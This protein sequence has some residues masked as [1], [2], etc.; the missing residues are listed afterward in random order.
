LGARDFLTGL[1]DNR[2]YRDPVE[3]RKLV[4]R[5]LRVDE[6]TWCQA[7]DEYGRRQEAGDAGIRL[8]I[9]SEAWDTCSPHTATVPL[10][11]RPSTCPICL[12][13]AVTAV[14]SRT[15]GEIYGLCACCGHG[16]LLSTPSTAAVYSQADYYERRS[17]GGVGYD[18]YRDERSYREAKA[19]KLLNWVEESAGPITSMLEVG[20]GYGFSRA[21]ANKRGW[22]T[23]GVDL[24]PAAAA[25]ASQIYGMKTFTGTLEQ[26]LVSGAVL[27]GAWEV[28]LYQFVLEHISDP[29]AELRHAAAACAPK[30]CITLLVPSMQAIERVVFGASYRSF[31]PDHLHL[32]SWR[33]LD[34][35]LSKAGL[36][37]IASRSECSVHLL[38]EF[39]TQQELAALYER[40]DG[41]DLVAIAT[42]ESL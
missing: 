13:L 11:A 33:S 42:K 1:Q 5:V 23:M 4:C 25:A 18:A 9:L 24:N 40:G 3:H 41:P 34:K 26:A 22:Q 12:Q 7:I 10:A 36:R 14:H 20:S 31:R 8:Q 2:F 39:L 16:V 37:R 35:C 27:P 21:A 32:F 30:G 19:E 17:N 29:V 6:S 38:A 28:V 15:S